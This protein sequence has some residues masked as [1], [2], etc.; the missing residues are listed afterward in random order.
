MPPTK[1]ELLLF[2]DVLLSQVN[3]Q[4][5][6]PLTVPAKVEAQTEIVAHKSLLKDGDETQ[7]DDDDEKAIQI[8]LEKERQN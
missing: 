3:V 6:N 2:G 8:Q 7:E 4:K 1:D 5:E